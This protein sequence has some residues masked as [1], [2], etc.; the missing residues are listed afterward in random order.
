M[1]VRRERERERE[2]EERDVLPRH[3][4]SDLLTPL[5]PHLF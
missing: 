3:A 1:E 2:K 5:G 4:P